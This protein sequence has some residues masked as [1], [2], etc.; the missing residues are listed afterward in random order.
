M[1]D[2]I[3]A[4][5]GLAI[6]ELTLGFYLNA[7][8]PNQVSRLLGTA[9]EFG[10]TSFDTADEYGHGQAI[11]NLGQAL[12]GR[13]RENVV[14]CSKVGLSWKDSAYGRGLSEKNIRQSLDFT[15]RNLD[16]DYLDLFLIHRLDPHTQ[17]SRLVSAIHKLYLQGKFLY[18]G[19]ARVK[20]ERLAEILLEAQC[21]GCPKPALY[22]GLYNLFQQAC[23]EYIFPFCCR[24][25]LGFVAHSPLSQG[26]LTGKYLAGTPKNSR[27]SKPNAKVYNL[28]QEATERVRKFV[29]LCGKYGLNPGGAAIA[30][31][32]RQQVVSSCA[33]G[34]STPQQIEE[35]C[36]TYEQAK[37]DPEFIDKLGDIFSFPKSILI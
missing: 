17:V 12:K 1:K 4:D 28:D 35:I 6:S 2:R 32:L 27:A 34:A 25:N 22:Q 14:L 5:T 30:W 3:L 10:I 9:I 7:A 15:L 13:V 24:L 23:E 31:T 37:A 16:T 19:V 11:K 36:R 18:W 33:F 26:V 20:P 29:D 8:D 21:Q